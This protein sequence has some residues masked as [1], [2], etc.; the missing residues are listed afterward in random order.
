MNKI[1]LLA[2]LFAFTSS[3]HASDLAATEVSV[4]KPSTLMFELTRASAPATLIVS[5][6]V[7]PTLSSMDPISFATVTPMSVSLERAYVASTITKEDGTVMLI[8]AKLTEGFSLVM[9]ENPGEQA[10]AEISYDT[11]SNI[12]NAKVD[13]IGVGSVAMNKIVVPLVPGKQV[14]NFKIEGKR[15]KLSLNYTPGTLN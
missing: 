6:V 7:S 1:A 5:G 9:R 11:I 10:V 14:K 15:Y 4:P 3:A 2:L 13:E 8:H 12:K